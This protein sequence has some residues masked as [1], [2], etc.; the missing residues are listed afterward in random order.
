MILCCMLFAAFVVMDYQDMRIADVSSQ[1]VTQAIEADSEL[2]E[3]WKD[4]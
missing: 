2:T 1:M 4:L 3:V